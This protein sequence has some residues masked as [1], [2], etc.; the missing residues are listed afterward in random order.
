MSTGKMAT[1]HMLQNML[2]ISLCFDNFEE[3]IAMKFFRRGENTS[4]MEGMVH[5]I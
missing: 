1:M 2:S 3:W 5:Y 4:N